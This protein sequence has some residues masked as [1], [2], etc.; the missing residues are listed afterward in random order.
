[1]IYRLILLLGTV[2]ENTYIFDKDAETQYKVNL[3]YESVEKA[4]TK[5]NIK[6][7]NGKWGT[8]TLNEALDG[9]KFENDYKKAPKGYIK[10]VC[11]SNKTGYCYYYKKVND[12]Y[13]V[14][15]SDVQN[16]KLKTYLFKTTDIDS[17]IYLNNY[18]YFING[19]LINYYY[20]NG[21]RKVLTD[22]ELEFNDD[23]SFGVYAK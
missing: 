18:I 4:G 10:A 19:N 1:M 11:K 9:K 21:V 3:K 6:Y 15:R 13:E 16:P 12:I 14:Y 7:Y 8:M 20:D 2:G 5:D 17:I 23:I 22:T